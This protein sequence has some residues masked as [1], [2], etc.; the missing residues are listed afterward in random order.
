MKKITIVGVGYVGLSLAVLLSRQHHVC[1]HDV[2]QERVDQIN[3]GKSPIEDRMISEYL[4]IKTLNL[5]AT[6]DHFVAYHDADYVII[7]T[8]TDYDEQTNKFDTQ[9]VE[10]VIDRIN[11]INSKATVIIKSTVPVGFTEIMRKRYP[12]QTIIFSPE[13]LREGYALQDNLYPNRIVIGCS[14]EYAKIFGDILSGAALS[15]TPV[16]YTGS[17]EAE[18][19]KLFA[20]TY[21][22]MRVAFFNEL[23][24]YALTQGLVAQEVIDGVCFDTRIGKGYNN[25]SFGYGGYCLPKDTKQLLVNY[26]TVPQNI[27]RAIVD[28]NATRKKFI[29]QDILKLKPKIVGIYRLVMKSGSDNFRSSSIHDIIELIAS[30]GVQVIV[31]EPNLDHSNFSNYL[32]VNDVEKFKSLADVVVANRL[33][34]D[35]SDIMNKVYSRDVYGTDS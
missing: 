16:L 34:S 15:S 21:L 26:Q 20:N 6:S 14:G 30:R 28:S 7:A 29:A 35:L 13:F 5:R 17:R 33:S 18:A 12:N 3:S 2:N 31:Y 23:D 25:P 32:L 11:L 19:I 22:A 9:S 24:S 1:A 4:S 27:I 10:D 8:P